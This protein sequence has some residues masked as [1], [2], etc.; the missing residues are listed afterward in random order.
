[1]LDVNANLLPPSF[2]QFT[3]DR[4]D[5][6]A[7]PHSQEEEDDDPSTRRGFDVL[8]NNGMTRGEVTAIRSYFSA[9]VRQVKIYEK[10]VYRNA[11]DRRP[12]P[13]SVTAAKK[14]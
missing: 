1:M 12:A 6:L 14:L 5:V 7:Q 9:E 10:R 8:R 3:R 11:F 4:V 2:W 13:R